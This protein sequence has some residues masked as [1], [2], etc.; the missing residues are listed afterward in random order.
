MS[1]YSS[2]CISCYFGVNYVGI[3]FIISMVMEWILSL[4]SVIGFDLM[5][6]IA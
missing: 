1:A 4:G 3:H 6:S 5:I 2:L